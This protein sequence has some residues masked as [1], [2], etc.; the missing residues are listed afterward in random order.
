MFE[1]GVCEKGP[2]R[3]EAPSSKSKLDSEIVGGKIILNRYNI[4]VSYKKQT[5]YLP[6]HNGKTIRKTVLSFYITLNC[7]K[8]KVKS[9]YFD[10]FCQSSRMDA[11]RTR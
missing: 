2:G 1:I 5:F 7:L 3:L 9:I 10:Y 6:Y 11:N 4:A 8:I